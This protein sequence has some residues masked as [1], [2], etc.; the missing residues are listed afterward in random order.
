MSSPL[1]NL[2]TKVI[3]DAEVDPE[4]A[5]VEALIAAQ[6]AGLTAQDVE[7]VK[8]TVTIGRF[9]GTQVSG[10]V[11]GTTRV[12][13]AALLKVMGAMGQKIDEK[14]KED[15]VTISP[16]ELCSIAEAMAK[17]SNALSSSNGILLQSAEIAGQG[18]RKKNRQNNA[19]QQITGTEVTVGD[20]RVRVATTSVAPADQEG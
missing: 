12:A 20:T 16:L 8:S 19:P 5:E 1:S 10:Y 13:Q 4:V 6:S 15:R 11:I 7:I 3:A 14:T 17:V 9:V 2:D 18:R